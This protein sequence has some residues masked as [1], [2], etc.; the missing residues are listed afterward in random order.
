MKSSLIEVVAW[1]QDVKL[2][3]AVLEREVVFEVDAFSTDGPPG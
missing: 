3:A 2:I 1:L